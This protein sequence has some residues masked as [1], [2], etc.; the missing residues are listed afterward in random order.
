MT[1]RNTLGPQLSALEER[2]VGGQLARLLLEHHRHGI[3]DRISE[4]NHPA[5][6][7]LG[8]ALGVVR[9]LA[10]RAG[11]DLEQ[12]RI[13]QVLPQASVPAPAFASTR[14]SNSFPSR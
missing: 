2:I 5:H 6:D 1:T 12:A 9:P 10:P 8:L 11:E 7:R 13:H 14:L 3:A 4:P